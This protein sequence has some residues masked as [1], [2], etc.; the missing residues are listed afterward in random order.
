MY[1]EQ[2]PGF[3]LAK[4]PVARS[5]GGVAIRMLSMM[6]LPSADGWPS[7][8]PERRFG[9]LGHQIPHLHLVPIL[10]V[11][12]FDVHVGEFDG[13]VLR[14]VDLDIAAAA[15]LEVLAFGQFH[16]ELLEE[17]RD[18]AVRDHFT[19]PLLDAQHRLRH[20]DLEIF[21]NFHLTAQAPVLLGH[22]AVDKARFG[23][24]QF[25][26]ALQHLTFAHA[27]R[28]AAAGM[29]TAG[30]RCCWPAS[31]AACRRSRR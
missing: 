26:A 30:T 7:N 6:I 5:N 2:I 9:I 21:L 15:E 29:P 13:I 24:Q 1:D 19:L 3:T 14:N 4:V 12:L 28:T 11:R 31:K 23:R 25:A 22:L 10:A 16:H 27:A 20:V 18:I 17:G 8:R